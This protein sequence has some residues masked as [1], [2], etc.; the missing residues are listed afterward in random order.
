[1]HEINGLQITGLPVA[2][3]SSEQPV[4]KKP[5]IGAACVLFSQKAQ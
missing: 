1:M 2:D 4:A 3:F 5:H